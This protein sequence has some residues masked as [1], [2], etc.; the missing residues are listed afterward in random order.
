MQ[1]RTPQGRSARGEEGPRSSPQ[2]PQGLGVRCGGAARTGH[3]GESTAGGGFTLGLAAQPQTSAARVLS[4]EPGEQAGKAGGFGWAVGDLQ[5]L[6]SGGI[7]P[8]SSWTVLT[9]A[10]PMD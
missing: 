3:G 6:A 8:R 4:W 10:F 1:P 2:R 9:L 5:P 7:K